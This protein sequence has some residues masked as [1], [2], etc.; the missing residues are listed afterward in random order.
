MPVGHNSDLYFHQAQADENRP[1]YTVP[2]RQR[3]CTQ[4]VHQPT[5]V[6]RS[7]PTHVHNRRYSQAPSG[8]WIKTSVGYIGSPNYEVMAASMV[9][10]ALTVGDV[11][12]DD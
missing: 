8:G 5:R 12:L 2:R 6:D 1:V 9:I 3:A 11:M 4:A 7:N 10:A